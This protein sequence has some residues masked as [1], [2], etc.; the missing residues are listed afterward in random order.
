MY[1]E[2]EGNSFVVFNQSDVVIA[3]RKT[4]KDAERFVKEEK[5]KRKA[6]NGRRNERITY[7]SRDDD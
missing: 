2:K 6:Q 1:I 3:T 4:L 5:G 7:S